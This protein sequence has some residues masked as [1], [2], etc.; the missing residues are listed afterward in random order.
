[1]DNNPSIL[2]DAAITFFQERHASLPTEVV[3]TPHAS[4]VLA[5]SGRVPTH[6]L[7]VKIA[8]REFDAED[9]VAIGAG[10]KIGCFIKEINVL[11]QSVEFVELK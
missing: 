3:I 9:A 4:L 7:G 2:L 5:A 6:F 8:C 10:S 11:Q 1:M